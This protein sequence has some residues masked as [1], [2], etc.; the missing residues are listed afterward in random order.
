[1]EFP[2]EQSHTT[3]SGCVCRCANFLNLNLFHHRAALKLTKTGTMLHL[4]VRLLRVG[5]TAGR[6]HVLHSP[7]V[8]K[9]VG[10][11]SPTIGKAVAITWGRLSAQNPESLPLNRSRGQS[12][13]IARGRYA[14]AAWTSRS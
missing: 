14:Q 9:S 11:V 1:M 2:L 5:K 7:L 10:S 12:S 8:R 3:Q 6:N 13:S 4:T